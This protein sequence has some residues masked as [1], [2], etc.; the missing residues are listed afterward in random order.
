MIKI[1]SENLTTQLVYFIVKENR[2]KRDVLYKN[3]KHISNL[4]VNEQTAQALTPTL[5]SIMETSIKND[6][7]LL[8][9]I[10]VLK[11]HGSTEIQEDMDVDDDLTSE[12]MNLIQNNSE[13]QEELQDHLDKKV[14]DSK[15]YKDMV[16]E[17]NEQLEKLN[18]LS[19]QKNN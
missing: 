13:E 8:K 12:L 19:N 18:N 14:E 6:Q 5:N 17:E 4:V 11:K 7:I 16:M 9:L 15:E 1:K 2:F 10:E 3:M